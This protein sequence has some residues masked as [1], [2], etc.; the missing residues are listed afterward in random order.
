MQHGFHAFVVTLRW[1]Q[2]IFLQL[3]LCLRYFLHYR[4][5]PCKMACMAEIKPW[6]QTAKGNGDDHCVTEVSTSN[7]GHPPIYQMLPLKLPI[8][9]PAFTCPYPLWGSNYSPKILREIHGRKVKCSWPVNS[10][11]RVHVRRSKIDR[12]FVPT[13]GGET[14]NLGFS[15]HLI[16]LPSRWGFPSG[17]AD[18]TRSFE[19]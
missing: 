6:C 4:Q 2:C 5:C 13:V 19:W 15:S 9:L 8:L 17:V 3:L 7:R 14:W 18:G 16:G 12:P 11:I 10:V 1:S